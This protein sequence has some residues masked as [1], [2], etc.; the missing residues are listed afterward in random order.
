MAH[1]GKILGEY[2][3]EHRANISKALKGKEKT[4]SHRAN[5]SKATTGKNR[6]THS[7]ETKRKM[8]ESHKGKPKDFSKISDTDRKRR[9]DQMKALR[10]RQKAEKLAKLA[11][12]HN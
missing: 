4:E 9:S 11:I 10:A 2:S 6:S 1:T 3:E 12:G 8:S 5:I 7:D